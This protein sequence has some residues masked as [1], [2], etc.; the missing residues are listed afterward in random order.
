MPTIDDMLGA[1]VELHQAGKL[2]E[3]ERIYREVLRLYPEQPHALNS[4][5][6]LANQLEKWDLAVDYLRRA[7]AAL[8]G[9]AEFHSNLGG[10]YRSAGNTT[11]AVTHYREALRLKPDSVSARLCLC[12]ALMDQ[13]RVEEARSHALEALRLQ[14]NNAEAWTLLGEFAAQGWHTFSAADVHHMESLLG[15]RRAEDH[16]AL[17]FTLAAYWENAGNYAEAF[18]YYRQGN[19][20]KWNIYRRCQ[21]AFD[22]GQHQAAVNDLMRAFTPELFSRKRSLG[23]ESEQPLFV[24]GMVRSGTTLVEQIL[25]SHPQVF[26]AG[27]LNDTEQIATLLPRLLPGGQGQLLVASGWNVPFSGAVAEPPAA[28]GYPACVAAVDATTLRGLAEQYLTSLAHLG[29]AAALRVVDKMPHNYQN[30]GLIALLFPRARI[31]HCRRDP[32][33]VCISA[34]VQKFK[35]LPYASR[36][37]DL[38]FYYRQYERLMEYWRQVLPLKIHEVVYEDMVADHEKVSRGLIAFCGLDWDD[39]CLEFYKSPQAVRTASRL[40]IR[41]PIYGS[42]V[43]RWK[44]FDP[45]L[46]PLRDALAD[47]ATGATPAS[48]P[49]R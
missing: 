25:A 47:R 12:N 31:V 5:G 41:R 13:G 44:R 29:G 26:G 2:A 10:A 49:G 37:E 1:A 30:L 43:G 42:S 36:L 17:H 40:Q 34:Y 20:V 9:Q 24:V 27:E 18:R 16:P 22:R 3:A 45:Y 6:V 33:D 21:K 7:V 14:P 38:G 11:A 4:L 8:P 39:R 28:G 32:L 35:W 15:D 46:Q 23:H 48:L 19:D